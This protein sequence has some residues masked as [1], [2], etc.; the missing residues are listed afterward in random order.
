MCFVSLWPTVETE[1]FHGHDRRNSG[2]TIPNL[3]LDIY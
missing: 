2:H 1:H 3:T